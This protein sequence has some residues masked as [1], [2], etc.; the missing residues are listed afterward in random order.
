MTPLNHKALNQA[1]QL[2]KSDLGDLSDLPEELRNTL[3][4]TY[5]EYCYLGLELEGE[6]AFPS[7][8]SMESDPVAGMNKFVSE[9]AHL[10]AAVKALPEV[11]RGLRGITR[12]GNENY[13][14]WTSLIL[15]IFKYRIPDAD[16]KTRSQLDADRAHY[17]SQ[18]QEIPNLWRM[19]SDV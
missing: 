1:R 5:Y 7:V 18:V 4:N 6:F 17:A 9:S 13:E 19:F 2:I 11:I 8:I 14:R 10:E 12:Q 16:K 15:D 3:A